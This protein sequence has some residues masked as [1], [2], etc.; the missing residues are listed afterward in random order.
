MNFHTLLNAGL[1]QI[2]W[3]AAVMGGTLAGVGA[4]TLLA[5]HSLA[6]GRAR[7]DL[8]LAAV[9][10]AIGF[11]LDT[12]W[13]QAGVLDYHGRLLAPP[14]IVAL[15]VAVGLSINHS[16]SM[17]LGRPWLAA[18]AVG[19]A[20]PFSYLGGAA[21]GG[22]TVPEPWQLA[23]VACVWGGLFAGVFGWVAPLANRQFEP[24]SKP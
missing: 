21:L 18:V 16:L 24:A 20:C 22:V 3:F 6:R 17:F 7:V 12:L 10:G 11:V 5:L 1:F 19:A 14:W 4:C 9:L 13:I 8:T 23:V 2:T 15:W